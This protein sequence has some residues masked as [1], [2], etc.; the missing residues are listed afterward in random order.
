MAK[1]SICI[2]TYNNVHEL[3]RLLHSIMEQTLQ[4]FEIIITDDSTNMEI[5]DLIQIFRD[6]RII[7]Q[8]N[9]TPLG[10]IFNW[11]KAL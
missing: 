7:Y 2:P 11:N 10:H 6:E 4:D 8:K 9:S 5:A 1:V 3:E